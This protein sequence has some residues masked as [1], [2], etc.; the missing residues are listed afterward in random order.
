MKENLKKQQKNRVAGAKF[1][2]ELVALEEACGHDLLFSDLELTMQFLQPLKAMFK[3]KRVLEI[4]CGVGHLAHILKDEFEVSEI[5]ATDISPKSIEKARE[6]YADVEFEVMKGEDLKFKPGSFDIVV[7]IET[8]EHIADY[9][10]HLKEVKRVLRPDGYYF[11]ETPNKPFNVI[12]ETLRGNKKG[13]AVWHPSLFSPKHLRSKLEE[14]GFEVKFYKQKSFTPKSKGK[15]KKIF[16]PFGDLIA[17]LFPFRF[18]PVG[19][20]PTLFLT[21]KKNE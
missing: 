2:D 1:Y 13:L 10:K 8:L 11:V 12:W 16:G 19:F 7:S 18:L 17:K 9:K 3:G 5:V 4:G 21:A 14:L 15:L 20:L 6:L